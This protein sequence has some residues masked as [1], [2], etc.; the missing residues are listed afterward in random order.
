M[1]L[2][3]WYRPA[4][5]ALIQPLAWELPYS[6]GATLKSKKEKKGKEKKKEKKTSLSNYGRK[7]LQNK[8][9]WERHKLWSQTNLSSRYASCS[10]VRGPIGAAAAGLHHSHSN[11]RSSWLLTNLTRIH[12]DLGLLPM[13]HNRNSCY[14]V[15][16]YH[17]LE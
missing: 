13:T 9:Q 11:A 6:A 7:I 4:A 2:R 5:A 12:E 17:K 3:L 10:Q 15:S 14:L 1:L 16:A 8:N